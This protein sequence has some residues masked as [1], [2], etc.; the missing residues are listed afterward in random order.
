MYRVFRRRSASALD[1][2]VERL[3]AAGISWRSVEAALALVRSGRADLLEKV[4]NGELQ[5]E[6]AWRIAQQRR[7]R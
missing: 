7:G 2:T 3:I 1:R 6:R 5:P 4:L